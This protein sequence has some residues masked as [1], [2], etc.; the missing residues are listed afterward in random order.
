MSAGCS[1]SLKGATC[2]VQRHFEK[3]VSNGSWHLSSFETKDPD[4]DLICTGKS[5]DSCE[6]K[7]VPVA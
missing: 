4:A 1:S 7:E 5:C 2:N 6:F 3:Q